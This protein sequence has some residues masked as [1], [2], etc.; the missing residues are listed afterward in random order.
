MPSREKLSSRHLMNALG[1]ACDYLKELFQ[2]SFSLVHCCHFSI[3]LLT[4][5]HYYDKCPHQKNSLTNALN[6]LANCFMNA[7]KR[8]KKLHIRLNFLPTHTHQW[9]WSN[10]RSMYMLFLTEV[11]ESYCLNFIF[12]F[13]NCS[14]KSLY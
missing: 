9:H 3:P 1:D 11:L 5:H 4:N 12:S 2:L 6:L 14:F 8:N 13:S 7:I 10:T